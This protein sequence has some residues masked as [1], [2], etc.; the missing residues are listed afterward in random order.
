MKV[1]VLYSN[2]SR[3][4]VEYTKLDDLAS[5]GLIVAFSLPGSD[6]WVDVRNKQ[7]ADNCLHIVGKKH[8]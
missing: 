8:Y 2:K 6:E 4:L 5:R 3:G 1:R 7:I